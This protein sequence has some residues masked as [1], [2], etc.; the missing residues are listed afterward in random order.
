[1]AHWDD[2]NF[3]MK[4]PPKDILCAT[5]QFRLQPVT[6]A[7][8]TQER[9]AYSECEKYDSKPVGIIW[10][11]EQCPYF[12]KE[13]QP[14]AIKNV[15]NTGSVAGYEIT[16]DNTE[17]VLAALKKAKEKALTMIGLKVEKYAKALCPVG[18]P[19]STGKAGYM[20]GT[21]RNSI[22]FEVEDDTLTAGSNV[23]Y[24]PYVE[25]GTGP[26]FDTPP[27]WL[28]YE[29]QKGSGIGGGYVKPRPFLRPA[30]QDHIP[31]YK[32]IIEN[33]MKNA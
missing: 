20:G 3:N 2:E 4:E 6:V 5:C 12:R 30:I 10:N 13:V 19:E 14:V 21:L 22:T 17:E 28:E 11:H 16:N 27:K 32:T 1:M 31:E 33:E 18:T 23:E 15:G 7:G 29:T 8:Y 25:L 9:Y 26:Y 24:A